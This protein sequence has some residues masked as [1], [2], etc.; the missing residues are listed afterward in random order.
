MH[1]GVMISFMKKP[2]KGA[3]LFGHHIFI[4]WPEHMCRG[5]KEVLCL[6]KKGNQGFLVIPQTHCNFRDREGSTGSKR[7][8]AVFPC[9]WEGNFFDSHWTFFYTTRS[10]RIDQLPVLSNVGGAKDVKL[11]DQLT[12]YP[13]QLT[14]AVNKYHLQCTTR[15][16][17]QQDQPLSLPRKKK[18]S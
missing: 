14:F 6:P 17:L 2:L 1:S 4:L 10:N 15:I 18:K 9:K 11:I 12:K 13:V 5:R 3:E 7:K 16:V 8:T